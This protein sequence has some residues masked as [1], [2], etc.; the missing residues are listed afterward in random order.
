MLL[1]LEGFQYAMSLDLNMGYYHTRSITEQISIWRENILYTLVHIFPHLLLFTSK[2][3]LVPF[4]ERKTE[5]FH[6]RKQQFNRYPR[7]NR[8]RLETHSTRCW[9]IFHFPFSKK[10]CQQNIQ[11]Y[12]Y[13]HLIGGF[14]PNQGHFRVYYTQEKRFAEGNSD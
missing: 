3:R 5:T 6:W 13:F 1:K 14:L 2:P 7:S 10:A 12:I 8:R 11:T 9:S 4:W